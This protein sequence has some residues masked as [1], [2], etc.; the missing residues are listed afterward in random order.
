MDKPDDQTSQN[1]PPPPFDG[2][3]LKKVA[4]DGCDELFAKM[5]SDRARYAAK[6]LFTATGAELGAS[7][8]RAAEATAAIDAARRANPD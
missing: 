4:S 2:Q 3:Q 1:T 8:V 5:R 6:A 7:A